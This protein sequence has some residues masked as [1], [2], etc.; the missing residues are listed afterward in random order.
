[1]VIGA[2]T[3]VVGA[4]N[5]LSFCCMILLLF[6]FPVT[7]TFVS[8]VGGWQDFGEARGQ[9][10]CLQNAFK[11]CVT[12]Q[13]PVLKDKNGPDFPQSLHASFVYSLPAWVVKST[14]STRVWRWS[15]VTKKKVSY[16]KKLAALFAAEILPKSGAPTFAHRPLFFFSTTICSAR[17][18][19]GSGLN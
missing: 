12:A 1:M 14:V 3:I 5:L 19:C 7:V 16:I 8:T 9:E 18:H 6:F 13:G 2:D 11:V 10:R 4:G 15:S 17:K